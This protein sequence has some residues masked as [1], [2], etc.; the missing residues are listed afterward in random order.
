MG[1]AAELPTMTAGLPLPLGSITC[2]GGFHEAFSE[3]M[4]WLSKNAR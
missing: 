2:G 3:S 1:T 4:A